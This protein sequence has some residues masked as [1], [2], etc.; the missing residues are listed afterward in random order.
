MRLFKS[1]IILILFCST[2]LFAYTFEIENRI[3]AEADSRGG[4]FFDNGSIF[5]AQ[6]HDGLWK[7]D[8]NG[9]LYGDTTSYDTEIYDLWKYND[10]FFAVGSK[11]LFVYDLSGN[12]ISALS[13][14]TGYSLYVQN[15]YAYITSDKDGIAIVDISDVNNPTL[16]TT[17]MTGQKFL[18]IRGDAL[19]GDGVSKGPGDH[20]YLT[21]ASGTLYLLNDDKNGTLTLQNSTTL[22][23]KQARRIFVYSD[24]TVYVSS[25]TGNL[26]IVSADLT[27]QT[28]WTNPDKHGGSTSPV[29]G[30]VFVRSIN[31]TRYAFITISDGYLYM[32]NVDNPGSISIEN[33]FTDGYKFNDLWVADS[34]I[35]LTSHDGFLILKFDTNLATKPFTCSS[36]S[37]INY[38]TS[39]T[40]SDGVGYMDSIS[41]VDGNTT[42][43]NTVIG[44]NGVTSIGYNVVDNFIWGYNI[45]LDMV[46]KIDANYN[47]TLFDVPGLTKQFYSAADVSQ[48]G[49]LHLLKYG[50]DRIYRVDLNTPTPENLQQMI[51]DRAVNTHDIAFN[52]VNGN[53][54]CT[55]SDGKLYRIEIAADGLSGQVKFVGDTGLG[56]VLP[57]M[58]YF[59][60]AGNYYA[61]KD[62]HNIYKVVLSSDGTAIDTVIDNFSTINIAQGDAARCPNAAISALNISGT[63]F[64]DINYGGGSGRNK[65]TAAGKARDNV[66]VELYD[67]NGTYISTTITDSYGAYSFDVA[68]GDYYIRVVNSSVTS[69]RASNS[70]GEIPLGV[71]TYRTDA[72]NGTVNPIN[73]EVGGRNPSVGDA[74]ANDGSSALDTTSLVFNSG[75][76][77]G[78]Q[79]QS[80]SKIKVAGSAVSGVDFGFNFSTIVNTNDE[81]QGS[82]RQFILNA[83]ELSN[84]GLDQAG[85]DNTYGVDHSV[86]KEASIFMIPTTDPNYNAS[87]SSFRI[88]FLKK[89]ADDDISDPIMLDGSTQSQ[90]AVAGH[91]V[92]EING[93]GSG[94]L[95]YDAIELLGDNHVVRSLAVNGFASGVGSTAIQVWGAYN[96]INS[97]YIGT[98]V[99]GMTEIPNSRGI[100]TFYSGVHDNMIG[101]PNP[102]QGNVICAND[103]GLVIETSTGDT[104]QNNLIGVGSDGATPIANDL[105]VYIT[106]QQNRFLDNVISGNNKSIQVGVSSSTS[107]D[108]GNI[109]QG[110]F[111]GTDRNATLN[112]GNGFHGIYILKSAS[113]TIIGGT[114]PGEA[115]IIANNHAHGVSVYADAS[116]NNRI[117]GNSFYNNSG[118]GIN[119]GSDDTITP[120]NGTKD[121]AKANNDMDYPIF[122][123][124]TISGTTLHVE[125]HVGSAANQ[126]TFANATVEIYK[127]DDDGDTNGEGRWYLGTCSSDASGNIDCNITTS[128]LAIGDYI[129]AT[130]TDGRGNTSEFGPN[131]TVLQAPP[132]TAECVATFPAAL[133]STSDLIDLDSGVRIYNTTDNTLITK[134]L[135]TGTDALCDGD[136]CQKSDTLAGTYSFTVDLGNGTDGAISKSGDLIDINSSKA[137]TSLDGVNGATCN[138]NGDLTIKSQHEFSLASKSTLNIDGNVTIHADSFTLGTDCTINIKSGNLIVYTNYAS[139]NHSAGNS[140]VNRSEEFVIFSKGDIDIGTQGELHGLFYSDAQLTVKQ[141][142]VITGAM[143]GKSVNIDPQ[144]HITYDQPAVSRYCGDTGKPTLHILD[145]QTVEGNSGMKAL[146]FEITADRAISGSDITID[147]STGDGSATTADSDYAGFKKR[148]VTLPVGAMSVIVPVT[149]NGDTKVESD[150]D[151]FVYIS[152]RDDVIM[153]DNYA[154][155]TILNDDYNITLNAVTTGSPFTDGNLTTQIVNQ[156]FPLTLGAY[157]GTLGQPVADMNITRI[158]LIDPLGNLY[159]NLFTGAATTGSDGIATLNVNVPAAYKDAQLRIT[160]DY[161]GNSYSNPSSDDFAI[162]PKAFGMTIPRNNIAGKPFAITLQATDYSGN[163]ATGYHETIGGSFDINFTEQKKTSCATGTM[164]LSGIAFSDG[165]AT[166]STTYSEVGMLDFN[167]SEIPGSEFAHVDADDTPDAQRYI[168]AAAVNDVNFIV[169]W[170]QLSNIQLHHGS[171]TFTYYAAAADMQNMAA[172][173][174]LTLQ[175]RNALGDIVKN[176][177]AGCYT[178]DVVIGVTFDTNSTATQP[179]ALSWQEDGNSSHGQEGALTFNGSVTDQIF[180]WDISKMHFYQGENNSSTLINFGRSITTPKEPMRFTIK[181]ITAVNPDN[182]GGVQNPLTLTTDFYYGRLHASDYMAVGNK[183]DAKIFHELYCDQ[184]DRKNVFTLAGGAESVDSVKWYQ[185]GDYNDAKSGFANVTGTK[186][187]FTVTTTQNPGTISATPDLDAVSNGMDMITFNVDPAKL[188]LM[189]RIYYLPK[190]WLIYKGFGSS[191]NR[192][193][194]DIDMSNVVSKW[195]GKGE[196][197]LTVDLNVSGRKGSMKI[198]W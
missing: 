84:T 63:I 52:P 120:N 143:T 90:Y 1:L 195:A 112:L 64:E 190:P 7:S 193:H 145:A 3:D 9:S 43:H 181:K 61:N 66:T 162:R 118:L 142:N 144:A 151:F 35:Y 138:I 155:G 21:D 86:I 166:H 133:S 122:T 11:G 80:I 81:G 29:A 191:D 38:N 121:S 53:I 30:G 56:S 184:C 161:L 165:N 106:G 25:E 23:S 68:D 85:I 111:I 22:F 130:A 76:L 185:V 51:L 141:G 146:S 172:D 150:E 96:T 174:T 20:L 6:H 101:G 183:L 140:V 102:S 97:C 71:Q 44:S 115:N 177:T 15:G 164:D 126:S 40:P 104:F 60:N 2:S 129:T 163:P 89:F 159:A 87:T 18:H 39:G 180:V 117:S 58:S 33:R 110:N 160:G 95:S 72:S 41:L 28:I 74:T 157:N 31:G 135:S 59:D 32:L 10:H 123:T 107:T 132:T 62:Q 100:R 98:D 192:H 156:R 168:P 109:F 14:V 19:Y 105:A 13:T 70:T 16:V 75:T 167:L 125:G 182:R 24:G 4:I 79:A 175:A 69:S 147:Y 179:N 188:P 148:H 57:Y 17:T 48:S 94:S 54:Y 173:L 113:D 189:D 114:N 170:I 108:Y 26:A 55:E 103:I 149:I 198:D 82:L 136:I 67:N 27:T 187:P 169:D 42:S 178:K 88:Q 73:T 158:D 49:I 93:Q 65:T 45:D 154:R 83:N 116:Q 47:A 8:A 12:Y 5:V 50:Q 77:S 134:L 152:S 36:Q 137:F 171:T 34:R 197:G 124:A 91:P 176:Y 46:S 99:T 194:F 119:L 139:L 127:V 78:A 153:V 196:R 37:Y 186:Y 131:Q 128:L 92:I